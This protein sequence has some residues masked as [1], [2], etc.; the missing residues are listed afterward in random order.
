MFARFAKLNT[1]R[2]E[3]GNLGKDAH[4]EGRKESPKKTEGN[5]NSRDKGRESRVNWNTA[6][7]SSSRSLSPTRHLFQ[8]RAFSIA[9]RRSASPTRADFSGSFISSAARSAKHVRNTGV[10]GFGATAVKPQAQPRPV[11]KRTCMCSP[12]THPGSFRCNL[13][14][15]VG[16]QSSSACGSC[17][18]ASSALN[19]RRSA[20]VNSIV[21]I[22]SVE[23]EWVKRALT[24]LIR[25]SS[26]HMRRREAFHP[27]PSRLRHVTCARDFF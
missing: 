11:R 3:D 1:Q 7:E 14:R 4:R 27:K 6:M 2:K 25:P 17:H 20:M 8:P 5:R 15:N 10:A 23:G 9:V 19:M 26:H 21:R 13:H 18:S 16:P 24:T 12:T 22:G